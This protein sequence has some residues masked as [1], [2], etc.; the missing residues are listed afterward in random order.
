MTIDNW[1]GTVIQRLDSIVKSLS[2][3]Y[4]FVLKALLSFHA[5]P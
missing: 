5:E 3:G 2:E 1:E 4:R